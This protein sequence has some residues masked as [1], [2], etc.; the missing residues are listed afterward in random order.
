MVQG[1]VLRRE[2]PQCM[3]GAATREGYNLERS[4]VQTLMAA[5]RDGWNSSD[6][7]PPPPSHSNYILFP[8]FSDLKLAPA[9]VAYRMVHVNVHGMISVGF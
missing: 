5:Q 7:P 6:C 1:E 2:R 8:F 9:V 4:H 3:L